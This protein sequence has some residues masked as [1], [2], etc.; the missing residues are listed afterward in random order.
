MAGKMDGIRMA[1]KITRSLQPFIERLPN[2]EKSDSYKG[3]RQK[4]LLHRIPLVLY[5]RS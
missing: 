4:V 3:K 5:D 2:M 1:S